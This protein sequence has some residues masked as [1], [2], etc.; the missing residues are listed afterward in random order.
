MRPGVPEDGAGKMAEEGELRMRKTAIGAGILAVL[1]M[2]AV[3]AWAEDRVPAGTSTFPP[4]NLKKVGDH[5]TPWN[6][7]P[8]GPDAYIIQR[9]D[10]LWDLSAKWLGNPRLWPQVWDLNR[11]VLD[12]HWIYPGD[13]LGVP[14]KPIVVPP[15]GPPATPAEEAVPHG[16]SEAPAPPPVLSA[17]PPAP[18]LPMADAVDVYCSAAIES[19]RAAPDLFVLGR[20]TEREAIAQ[21]DV[22]YLNKGRADGM[23]AGAEFQVQRAAHAVIHPITKSDLGIF[24]LRLGKIRV[25]AVQ[26]N[27]ATAVIE[28][29]CAPIHD[30]DEVVPWQ[31]I[32]IPRLASLPRFD[33]WNVEPSGGTGGYV[34]A[35]KDDIPAVG[36]GYV[37]YTDIGSAGGARPGSI[38]RVFR[39]RAGLPRTMLGQ[40]VV[41]ETGEATSTAKVTLAV[42]EIEI[43][44]RV[45]IEP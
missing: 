44:D 45:E 25:I 19:R 37:I 2:S 29:S 16:E 13:P 41:I 40:A 8:A 14:G 33:R 27:T 32:P 21:G 11:Y 31:E 1:M 17:L 30:K 9:G 34:I 22:L 6:P 20:E 7:P 18:L 39:E 42:K 35:A 5:W 10:T 15:G 23:R 28:R 26:E 24:V 4:K 36:A 43:G 38:L 3:A 12:S